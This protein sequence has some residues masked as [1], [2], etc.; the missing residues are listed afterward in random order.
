MLEIAMKPDTSCA[1]IIVS[2][3]YVCTKITLTL[4]ESTNGSEWVRMIEWVRI[5]S[6]QNRIVQNKF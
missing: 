5:S 1:L 3:Q 4:K 6:E 2:L